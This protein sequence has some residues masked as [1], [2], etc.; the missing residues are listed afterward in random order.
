MEPNADQGRRGVRRDRG[1]WPQRRSDTWLLQSIYPGLCGRVQSWQRRG[2]Y[3]LLIGLS[4]LGCLLL[5]PVQASVSMTT[6]QTAL[7]T[8]EQGQQLYDRGELEA[9]T[10]VLE[11]IAQQGDNPAERVVA[12]RNL[13][14]VYQQLGQ[15]AAAA[16]AI[17]QGQS[18]LAATQLTHTALLQAQ[19]LEVQGSLQ[20]DQGQNTAAIKTWQQA[21][22]L[23]TQLERPEAVWQA[24]VNQAQAL[25]HL[26]FHRQ[27]VDDLQPV[28]LAMGNGA[29][30]LVQAIALRVLGESL[31]EVGDLSA[32]EAA[33]LSSQELAQ[34]LDNA[35]AA[36]SA[37][38]S[39]GN[40]KLAQGEFILAADYYQAANQGPAPVLV[41]VQAQVNQLALAPQ[42]PLQWTNI[43]AIL[44]P[45]PPTQALL[46]TQIKLAQTL[47]ERPQPWASPSPRQLATMLA[48]TLTQAQQLGDRR[49]ESLAMGTLGH[50]YEVMAQWSEAAALSES[51]LAL[52]QAI[53][54]DDITYRWQWQLGRIYYAEKEIQSAIAAYSQAVETLAR[55]RQDLV[56]VNPS[57]QVSFQN[58]VE[59]LH[60]E[61]VALLLAPERAHTQP[62]LE[63]ARATIESLQLAELDNFFREACL[64]TAAVDIDQLDQTAAVIYP[65]ILPDRLEIIV[66]LPDQGLRNYTSRV[67]ATDLNAAVAQLQQLLTLRIGRGYLPFAQQLYDWMIRP[68][69]ADLATSEIETLVFVLDGT[70][71]NIPMAALHDGEQFLLEH[72][73]IAYTPG[74][75]LINPRPI[76]E[77][78]LRVVTAGLSEAR[79]GF[80]ALPNVVEEVE[81]I[82][83]TVP[84]AVL[85]ND[86][87][88]LE[89]LQNSLFSEDAPIVHL[90]SHGQFSSSSEETFVLT[91]DNR[92]DITTLNNLLQASEL[93]RAEPIELLVLSACQ[94]A[95]GD[96]LAAL[97]LAGMAVRSGARSTVA[98]LWQVNDEATALL[99]SQLYDNLTHSPMSKADALRQAQ[100]AVLQTPQFRQHPFYWSPYVL[101]GNWL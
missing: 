42:T 6:V 23:Y 77:Q 32:A 98:T 29:P 59:P 14:L 48:K 69:I 26:G 36:S 41:Q 35:A 50:L 34:Q 56:A 49:A 82:Q 87:F 92:L 31:L 17:A 94:T 67:K 2:L 96:K 89:A 84:S 43:Q 8:L 86:G 100:L 68:A 70:L 19:L 16:A 37:A 95:A 79:Q 61:L 65:V 73:A 88:T 71:R 62:D 99:M 91:W 93:N 25:Q 51:A 12:L 11:A 76:Q 20:F 58:S 24:Q 53:T 80:S 9:A 27:V 13:A 5:R 4:C 64:S 10:Q 30:T 63:Q 45:L 57:V 75:Q 52:A 46:F 1:P 3:G 90:A 60:R 18:S 28:V 74:L 101:V 21:A 97:G 55:L 72:Y 66:S 81:Q 83:A 40:L 85:L 78:T 15:W 44:E 54:A 7:P 33:L 22:A 39:L 47:M 38:L